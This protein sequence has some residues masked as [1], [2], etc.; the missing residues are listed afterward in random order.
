MVTTDEK[1]ELEVEVKWHVVSVSADAR[2]VVAQF[3]QTGRAIAAKHGSIAQAPDL[4]AII[5]SSASRGKSD[6]SLQCQVIG[7]L[8]QHG[9]E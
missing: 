8:P 5:D 1:L 4:H 9:L 6:I 7:P 2:R 3:M